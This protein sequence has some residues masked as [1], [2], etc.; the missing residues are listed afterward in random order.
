MQPNYRDDLLHCESCGNQFVFTIGQ[1]RAQFEESGSVEP[2]THCPVCSVRI[3][4][5]GPASRDT[6]SG[7]PTNGAH[8]YD[9]PSAADDPPPADSDASPAVWQES[10]AVPSETAEEP[11]ASPSRSQEGSHPLAGQHG[12]RRRGT[13]KWFNDRKGF[14]FITLDD[15]NEIFVHYSGIATEGYKTLKDGQ[16]V[17]FVIEDTD[18][19]PQ[20]GQV[21]VI[22]ESLSAVH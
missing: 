8:H 21:T 7:V 16:E 22:G 6:D 19:G 1:Q 12:E 18:K 3:E 17:E 10:P 4:R 20:A 14:G 13:V 11:E 2:P 5:M 9:E 15:G